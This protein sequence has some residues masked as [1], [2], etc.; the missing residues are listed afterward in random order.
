A[1]GSQRASSPGPSRGAQQHDR[2]LPDPPLRPARLRRP[3]RAV[4][5]L[6]HLRMRRGALGGGGGP[7]LHSRHPG[8]RPRGAR[9]R[10]P[11]LTPSSR[12][13]RRRRL[14]TGR[15]HE[16]P[17]GGHRKKENTMKRTTARLAAAAALTALALAGCGTIEEPVAAPTIEQ[18]APAE[19]AA[20][21]EAP[22]IEEQ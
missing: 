10:R 21:A 5:R 16:P 7:R 8:G 1:A 14:K 9:G 22:A 17:P 4:A 2:P 3:P 12:P 20:A 11:P 15:A 19:E 6:L 13:R 18:E